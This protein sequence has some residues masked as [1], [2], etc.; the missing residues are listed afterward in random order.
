[1]ARISRPSDVDRPAPVDADEDGFERRRTGC[2]CNC[3]TAHSRCAFSPT[4]KN[5]SLLHAG[6]RTPTRRRGTPS[7]PGLTVHNR[8]RLTSGRVQTMRTLPLCPARKQLST[9]HRRLGFSA[10]GSSSSSRVSSPISCPPVRPPECL[11]RGDQCPSLGAEA[12]SDR[13]RDNADATASAS[14]PGPRTNAHG[15][16]P[17]GVRGSLPA[18]R[19]GCN[20]RRRKPDR[21]CSLDEEP[22]LGRRKV[23]RAVQRRVTHS[24]MP[25]ETE[26][27][28]TN[29]RGF[30]IGGG[31]RTRDLRVMRLL[32][33]VAWGGFRLSRAN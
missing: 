24:C 2:V 1:M 3:S 17:V 8:R 5:G 7:V 19:S 26:F 11:S 30:E 12:L 29:R 9:I 6:R 10:S 15:T 31:I 27:A 14:N 32:E 22:D 33:G 20:R 18:A 21:R 23:R 13:V 25:C 4:A 28:V 16:P